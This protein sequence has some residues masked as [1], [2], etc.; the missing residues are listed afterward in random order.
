MTTEARE[1]VDAIETLRNPGSEVGR[2]ISVTTVLRS[3]KRASSHF[4]SL[5]SSIQEQAE[6]IINPVLRIGF[7]LSMQG[8]VHDLQMSQPMGEAVLSALLASAELPPVAVKEYA[9]DQTPS[10]VAS[11]IIKHDAFDGGDPG[12][13]GTPIGE[14][15]VEPAVKVRTLTQAK[16]SVYGVVMLRTQ[17]TPLRPASAD[18]PEVE[19]STQCEL[20][21]SAWL[22]SCGLK[23]GLQADVRAAH[24]GLIASR[25][26]STDHFLLQDWDAPMFDC[27]EWG[28][29]WA[30]QVLLERGDGSVHDRNPNGWTPLHVSRGYVPLDCRTNTLTHRSVRLLQK[31][32]RRCQ[33][34]DPKR[35]GHFRSCRVFAR[36]A[37]FRFS[38]S[39]TFGW[40]KMHD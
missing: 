6:D 30:L 28:N 13:T 10:P 34:F 27:A 3:A 26:V 2:A 4:I 8:A 19:V 29:V 31:Q 7:T 14:D 16:R 40:L 24:E 21:P 9:T 38:V 5:K 35:G 23:Y 15:T 11:P 39:V 33:V 22:L 1:D 17:L 25:S 18:S 20:H 37:Q 36:L 12:K 32:I